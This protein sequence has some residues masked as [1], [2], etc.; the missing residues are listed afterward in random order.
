MDFIQL[1]KFIQNKKYYI[2]NTIQILFIFEMNFS[3]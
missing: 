1:Y 3:D 2:L